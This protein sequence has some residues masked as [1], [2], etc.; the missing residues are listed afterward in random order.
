M[1]SACEIV[2]RSRAALLLDYLELNLHIIDPTTQC[3]LSGSVEQPLHPVKGEATEY[4]VVEVITRLKK[5]HRSFHRESNAHFL[6]RQ[7]TTW[8]CVVSDL[9]IFCG[10]CSHNC[11][12]IQS[13]QCASKCSNGSAENCPE[14]MV[15]SCV[16]L[17]NIQEACA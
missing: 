9:I 2:T 5:P 14:I 13:V 12:T 3:R 6:G 11:I 1:I 7:S 16:P 8:L 4:E 15:R 17:G 10:F